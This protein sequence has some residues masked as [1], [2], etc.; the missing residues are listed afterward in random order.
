M[1][2][3][4]YRGSG[5]GIP[6]SDNSDSIDTAVDKLVNI[7]ARQTRK[8]DTSTAFSPVKDDRKKACDHQSLDQE[9]E[10]TINC[11]YE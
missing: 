11:T 4:D 2:E 1:S 7:R 9:T 3:A 6:L 5:E 10:R 8:R